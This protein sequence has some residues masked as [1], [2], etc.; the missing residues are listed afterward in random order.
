MISVDEIIG[1]YY[2]R[3]NASGWM[4]HRMRSVLAHYEGD[5]IVPLPE[6]QA[7]EAPGVANLIQIGLDQTAMRISSTTPSVTHHPASNSDLSRRR[8]RTRQHANREWWRQ[9]KVFS[10]QIPKRARHMVGY[11]YSVADVYWDFEKEMPCWRVRDPLTT[12][13]SQLHGADDIAPANCIFAGERTVGW[14]R[15]SFPEHWLKFTNGITDFRGVEDRPVTLLEYVDAEER[16]LVAVGSPTPES[17]YLNTGITE[18][19][20]AVQELQRVPNR[21]GMTPVTVSER[22]SLGEDPVGQ[23]DQIRGMFHMQA[24][25]MSLEIIAARKGVFA[26]TWVVSRP[27]ERATIVTPA[28]GM[29]GQL[30][31]V[32]GGDIRELQPAPGF[33]TNPVVDRLERAMRLTSAIPPEYGGESG[34]NIRTGRRGEFVLGAAVDFHIQE[35][36]RTFADCLEYENRVAVQS[37]KG[38]AGSKQFSMYVRDGRAKGPTDFVPDRDFESDANTVSYSYAGS[39]QNAMVI[40]AAQRIN[41]GTLSRRN[42]MTI[43]PM[44]EDPETEHDAVVAEGIELALMQSIQQ[45][46]A[47]GAI[48][49]A[50]VARIMELVRSDKMD[51]ADAVTKAQRE[52]QERQAQQVE[53]TAPEAMPGLAQPGMGAEAMAPPPEPEGP[54]DLRQLLGSL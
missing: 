31:E 46:A 4:K 8:A 36:Q 22:I 11:S 53:A 13:P 39:D 7:N 50:D 9:S 45:Q 2:D 30:G 32:Q 16:V 33:M 18:A 19:R 49:P 26:D 27:G 54:P 5:V 24:M 15:N 10:R 37:C 23:F 52:A 47:Q 29:K 1:L 38:W 35:A 14:M 41:M 40:S 43:D 25:L 3:E 6:L 34:S 51:L 48:P 21:A 17:S 20:T 44:V 12:Y 42:F 28:D